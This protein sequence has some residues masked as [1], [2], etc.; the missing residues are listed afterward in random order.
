MQDLLNHYPACFPKRND[1]LYTL[2]Q[3]LDRNINDKY[4]LPIIVNITSTNNYGRSLKNILT[5]NTGLLLVDIYRIDSI[6]AQYY[7]S[8]DGRHHTHR[9]RLTIKQGKMAKASSKFRTMKKLSKSLAS[10]TTVNQINNPND[11]DDDD[12]EFDGDDN[13]YHQRNLVKSLN[14]KRSSSTPLCRI[15]LEYQR[16][17]E[18]LNENDQSIE[19]YHKLTDLIINEFDNKDPEKYI[20]KWPHAFFLRSSCTAYMKRNT[21][22]FLH[23]TTNDRK[24][25][26]TASSDSCYGSSSDLDSQKNPIVLDDEIHVLQAGQVLTIIGDCFGLHTKISDKE[27]QQQQPPSPS[28]SYFST[29]WIRD[30]SRMFFSKK[31]RQSQTSEPISNEIVNTK[32]FTKKTERYLKCQTQEGEIV[33]ISLQESGLFSPLNIQ[34]YRSKSNTE[35]NR[36]DISGVFQLKNLLSNIRLPVSVRHLDGSISFDNIFSIASI[37]RHETPTKLRLVMPYSEHVIYACPLNLSS[38]TSSPFIVIPLSVNADIEIQ[39][40]INMYDISKTDDF[41][42]ILEICY[43]LIEQYQT[44]ISLIHFP[45]QIINEFNQSKQTLHKKRSQSESFVEY[46]DEGLTSNFRHSDDQLNYNTYSTVNSASPISSPLRYRDS[47]ETVKQKLSTD[48][49]QPI[50]RY[51]I[52][53]SKMK[54]NQQQRSSRDEYTSEDEIYE[55]LDK[56]YDY[57]RSGNVTDDVQKIQAKD[58]VYNRTNTIDTSDSSPKVSEQKIPPGKMMARLAVPKVVDFMIPENNLD[59][60]PSKNDGNVDD[61]QAHALYLASKQREKSGSQDSSNSRPTTKMKRINK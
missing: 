9:H 30:K 53:H 31:H 13:T 11:N 37:N 5:K 50:N 59:F 23:S 19:P 21:S 27:Q 28:S 29:S 14:E 26:S 3:F 56:I 24:S 54:N 42:K 57:I 12:D 49:E 61:D 4:Q 25:N 36:M 22:E 7:R 15:P 58:R 48:T 6:V 39:P 8:Q 16:Y 2:K 34:T 40:C 1:E 47:I 33:Y 52:Y 51:S 32:F 17:F 38:K 41:Q 60:Y 18:L 35:S 55:D 10:L 44:G 43:Q 20:E 46:I 45:L